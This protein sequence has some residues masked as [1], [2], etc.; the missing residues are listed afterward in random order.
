MTR[1]EVLEQAEGRYDDTQLLEL[2][3]AIDFAAKKHAGQ[4]RKSGEAYIIH[5]LAVAGR[6][7]GKPAY[8]GYTGRF[9]CADVR[10]VRLCALYQDGQSHARGI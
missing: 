3:S 8:A 1:E 10:P 9:H 4:T 7:D 6:P 5:P 2:A